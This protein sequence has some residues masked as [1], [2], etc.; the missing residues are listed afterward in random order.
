MKKSIITIVSL[1]AASVLTTQAAKLTILTN[2]HAEVS[3]NFDTKWDLAL[4]DETDDTNYP[5]HDVLLVGLPQTRTEVP[6]NSDYSFL[7]RPGSSVWIL[8]QEVDPT[9]LTVGISAEDMPSGIFEADQF[10][11]A[12]TSVEGPGQFA[13]Y[14]VEAFG[15]PNVFVNT[16]GG[17]NHED[18]F[19]F[20]AGGHQHYN[21]AFSKPGIYEV[22]F[23]ASGTLVNG[24][25]VV[26]RPVRYT[27]FLERQLKLHLRGIRGEEVEGEW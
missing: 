12:V 19:G 15:T 6:T 1:L 7:G 24:T 26:S 9:I 18:S 13:L 25:H 5:A 14:Q 10:T 21:W 11:L 22:T 2:V 23:R 16:R 8:P 4:H 17:L 27:F 3:I 20:A